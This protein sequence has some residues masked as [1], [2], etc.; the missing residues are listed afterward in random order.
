MQAFITS[1]VIIYGEFHISFNIHK[2]N[3]D[4]DLF[5]RSLYILL[6]YRY[7]LLNFLKHTKLLFPPETY[8]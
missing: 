4:G 1:A 5:L 8:S 2:T 7:S 6:T 3:G